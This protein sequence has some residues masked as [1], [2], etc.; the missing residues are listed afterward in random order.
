MKPTP[1][2]VLAV[3]AAILH[4]GRVLLVR[5]GREPSKGLYAFPG[6]RVE[7][8][9]ALE[10]AARRELLEETALTAGPLTP[11]TTVVIPDLH[12]TPVFELTV[13]FG[14]EATGTLAPGDD[15]ESAGWFDAAEIAALP[16]TGNVGEIALRLIAGEPVPRFSG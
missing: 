16:V 13:F 10:D 7:P 12:G 15:A 2:P 5:R 3:S 1:R 9:E 11:L 6:G 4:E 14:T 8:G